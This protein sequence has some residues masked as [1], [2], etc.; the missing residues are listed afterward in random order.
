MMFQLVKTINKFLSK[1]NEKQ[2]QIDL[3]CITLLIICIFL[4]KI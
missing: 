4:Q 1:E 3:F 2:K